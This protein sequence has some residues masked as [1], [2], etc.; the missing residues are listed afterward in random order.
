MSAKK[1]AAKAANEE[2]DLQQLEDHMKLETERIVWDRIVEQLGI[3]A[4]LTLVKAKDRKHSFKLSLS[5]FFND[6]PLLKVKGFRRPSLVYTFD[7][8]LLEDAWVAKLKLGKEEKKYPVDKKKQLEK[9]FEQL[10]KKLCDLFED[11]RLDAMARMEKAH[12][13][14]V[15]KYLDQMRLLAENDRLEGFWHR[16]YERIYHLCPGISNSEMSDF[17]D[18]IGN[19]EYTQK[20]GRKRTPNMAMGSALHAMTLSP[21]EFKR[22][23]A[24]VPKVE[25]SSAPAKRERGRYE[26]QNVGLEVIDEK[27]EMELMAQMR[28]VKEHP[29]AQAIWKS[30]KFEVSLFWK[31]KA[32]GQLLRGRVDIVVEKVDKKLAKALERYGF[33]NIKE[34][35]SLVVDLKRTDSVEAGLFEK[36]LGDFGYP[37]Q[38]C[39]YC[40]GV[41]YF[42]GRKTHFLLMAVEKSGFHD[43]AFFD[44][45]I[46][47]QE[48]AQSDREFILERYA[49]YKRGE[50]NCKYRYKTGQTIG[51]KPYHREEIR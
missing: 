40:D 51:Y 5:K 27:D 4:K 49:A 25:G 8:D 20:H 17:K 1:A 26:F 30:A 12:Q 7:V 33:G 23:Y 37:R 50:I 14:L 47:T 44:L 43:V 36:K 15:A 22:E 6:L 28:A 11:I 10:D 29:L 38:G 42:T 19:Y 45:D 24:V 34:G 18:G 35:D 16:I 21:D 3:K 41:S 31:H 39:H 9:S 48:K 13:K 2:T 46:P 32:T